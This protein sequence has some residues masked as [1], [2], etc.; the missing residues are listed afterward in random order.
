MHEVYG[1]RLD[2]ISYST[3]YYVPDRYICVEDNLLWN[4][5]DT[6]GKIKVSKTQFIALLK[7]YGK[8]VKL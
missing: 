3:D 8:E 5:N 6:K 2:L 7:H 4:Y 1:V